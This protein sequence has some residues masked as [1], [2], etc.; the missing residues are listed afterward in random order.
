MPAAVG[1]DIVAGAQITTGKNSMPLTRILAR[2]CCMFAFASGLAHAEDPPTFGVLGATGNE[3]RLQANSAELKAS[4]II[5]SLADKPVDVSVRLSRLRDASGKSFDLKFVVPPAT[6]APAPA[7]DPAGATTPASLEKKITVA[8]RGAAQFEFTAY[9]EALGDYTG[10]LVVAEGKTRQVVKLFVSRADAPLGLDILGVEPVHAEIGLVGPHKVA[11]KFGVKET[12][13]RAVTTYSPA[14]VQSTRK[15]NDAKYQS[16]FVIAAES[17]QGISVAPRQSKEVSIALEGF[18]GAGEYSGK[19]HLSGAG[20]Q[21][22]EIDFTVNLQESIWV[23]SSLILFGAFLSYLLPWLATTFRPRLVETQRLQRIVLAIEATQAEAGRDAEEAATLAAM[24]SE[25]TDLLLDGSAAAELK[26]RIDHF[27]ARRALIPAW[28]VA[29][30]KALALEPATVRGPFVDAVNIIRDAIRN[31]GSA[32]EKLTE[33]AS[34]LATLDGEM[35]ASVRKE[36][37]VQ[38]KAIEAAIK[39][40]AARP[41]SPMSLGSGAVIKLLTEVKEVAASD[42]NRALVLYGDARARWTGLVLDDF[43]QLLAQ[44]APVTMD[45]QVWA[46]LTARLQGM[47]D[48][49]TAASPKNPAAAIQ[50]YEKAVR[51]YVSQVAGTVRELLEPI[52]KKI[53]ENIAAEDLVDDKTKPAPGA[54]TLAR[55]Y[56]ADVRTHCTAAFA[57]LRDDKPQEALAALAEAV[58][59]LQ[60]AAASSVLKTAGFAGPDGVAASLPSAAFAAPLAAML[61]DS[62]RRAAPPRVS[63]ESVSRIAR[64]IGAIDIVT[65]AVALVI[66]VLLGLIALWFKDAT[67]GGAAD[68]VGALLWG[69]GLHQFAFAGVGAL[70]D[71]LLG[72]GKTA[73]A[74]S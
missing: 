59:A 1:R 22:K 50:W 18:E 21:T 53:E 52:A 44:A 12:Q 41:E 74:T 46:R 55:Q 4:V 10:E 56:V 30:R 8:A 16:M 40:A 67:W 14:L 2:L 58:R 70:R 72:T 23:A 27:E 60:R 43:R 73:G 54:A 11:L 20:Q 57:A 33:H 6:A 47:L 66:T 7:P 61:D 45:A 68:R 49:A 25:A 62:R 9:L 38:L 42:L 39:G 19:I 69:L 63:A 3:L 37:D 24:R 51:D 17:A 5:E 26:A 28:M 64:F 32:K 29:R 35:N 15:L 34:K 36:L 71:K 48:E 13:S 31:P 65:T